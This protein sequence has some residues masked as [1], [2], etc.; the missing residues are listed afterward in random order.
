[1][2]VVA[3][4]AAS[5]SAAASKARILVVE[6]DVDILQLTERALIGAGYHVEAAQDGV[7]GWE[8]L[9]AGEFDL[10]VTDHDMPRLTGLEL[11]TRV[12]CAHKTL[13]V[14]LATGALPTEG[15][16]RH[17]WLQ[18]AATLLK[19]FSPH[20]MLE[21]VKA[22]LLAAQ[23]AIRVADSDNSGVPKYV[24]LPVRNQVRTD[25]GIADGAS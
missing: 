18:V 21:S 13:P 16:E 8:A 11:I 23:R 22:V 19:P 1:M 5:L 7:A 3:T 20:Q 9:N 12:R 2:R 6:D 17:S 15:L 10:M 25:L 14:I 4:A 24:I